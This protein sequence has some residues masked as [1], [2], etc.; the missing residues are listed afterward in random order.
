MTGY[1]IGD[2]VKKAKGGT[3]V[4]RAI[5][6]TMEGGQRYAI[7]DEGVLDFVD[8]GSLSRISQTDLAAA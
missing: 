7:E 8:E 6:T 3:G 5:F 1:K 4:V 2:S